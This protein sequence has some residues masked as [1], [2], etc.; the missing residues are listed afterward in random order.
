MA[1]LASGLMKMAVVIHGAIVAKK[2]GMLPTLHVVNVV[3][4][5]QI[6]CQVN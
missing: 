3:E 2:M 6:F 4:G 5:A 1:I